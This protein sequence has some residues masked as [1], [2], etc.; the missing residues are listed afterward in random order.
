MHIVDWNSYIWT[1]GK[2]LVIPAP[3]ELTLTHN[4]NVFCEDFDGS[5]CKWILHRSEI[6]YCCLEL[7]GHL[8]IID[9]ATSLIEIEF[10][11]FKNYLLSQTDQWNEIIFYHWLISGMSIPSW[12][13]AN[14][15]FEIARNKNKHRI[16]KVYI[17]VHLYIWCLQ[18]HF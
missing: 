8:E 9:I 4:V 12:T 3:P 5:I 2:K 1:F 11:K 10:V 14:S 17:H 16:Y 18:G 15:E 7:E 6:Q 13:L